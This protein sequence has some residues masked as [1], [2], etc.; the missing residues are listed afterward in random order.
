MRQL[1]IPSGWDPNDKDHV[2]LL[3]KETIDVGTSG[4][5]EIYIC[6]TCFLVSCTVQL[7]ERYSHTAEESPW[8]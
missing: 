1:E 5:I 3:T 4:C 8:W 7:L 2:A 6:V